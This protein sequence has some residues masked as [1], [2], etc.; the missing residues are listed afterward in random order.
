[1]WGTL[2]NSKGNFSPLQSNK[3]LK[4]QSLVN[5]PLKVANAGVLGRAALIYIYV[6]LDWNNWEMM[7]NVNFVNSEICNSES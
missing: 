2:S 7:E 4:R 5:Y 1:M 6:E 3:I